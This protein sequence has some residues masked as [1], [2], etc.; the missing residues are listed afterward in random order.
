M[1]SAYY[2]RT[3]VTANH[4]IS[5]STALL[6]FPSPATSIRIKSKLPY[7][8]YILRS[9]CLPPEPKSATLSSPR[10]TPGRTSREMYMYVQGYIFVLYSRCLDNEVFMQGPI[11]TVDALQFPPSAIKDMS[12]FSRTKTSTHCPWKGDASYYTITVGSKLSL[13]W[14]WTQSADSNA[15]GNRHGLD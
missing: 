8:N 9:T 13:F 3:S 1:L 5:K 12:Q 2:K 6:E 7:Q 14:S 15:P 10:P 11:L 4:P